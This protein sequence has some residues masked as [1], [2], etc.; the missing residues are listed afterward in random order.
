MVSGQTAQGLRTRFFPKSRIG[1]GVISLAPWLNLVLLL[2]FFLLLEH[3]FVLQPGV[4]IRLPK[5]P[6]TDGT[7]AG[8]TAVIL[9]VESGG[10]AREEIVIFDDERFMARKPE[11]MNA[12]RESIEA[13][14][15]KHNRAAERLIILA[16]EQVR[17]GTVSALVSMAQD[18]GV[19]EVNIAARDVAQPS[20][21]SGISAR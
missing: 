7:P 11:R 14:V 4:V 15:R 13:A 5:A 2:V 8:M 12:L 20:G 18:A 17:H 9:S 1:Q 6:F 16:D 10:G 19:K 3:K 21:P